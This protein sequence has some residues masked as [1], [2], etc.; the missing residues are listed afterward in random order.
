MVVE[1]P[2]GSKKRQFPDFRSPEV[3]IS[4]ITYPNLDL[5]REL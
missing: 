4:A 5:I 1:I 3:G 2:G